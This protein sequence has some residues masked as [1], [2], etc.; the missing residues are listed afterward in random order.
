MNKSPFYA[1]GEMVLIN[2][3]G[4]G[5]SSA[6]SSMMSATSALGQ[7]DSRRRLAG[8]AAACPSTPETGWPRRLTEATSSPS[9]EPFMQKRVAPISFEK[10]PSQ[11]PLLKRLSGPILLSSTT[12]G[13]DHA[14]SDRGNP[15]R[16]SARHGIKAD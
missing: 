6:M 4:G 5:R 2:A 14:K 12:L 8:R 11:S 7:N 13:G 9:C 15:K 3:K 10:K 16:V 1:R